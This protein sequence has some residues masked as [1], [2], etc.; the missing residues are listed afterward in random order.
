M[1]LEVSELMEYQGL[2]W[3]LGL[4]GNVFPDLVKVFFTNLKVKE[5]K[6]E[7]RVKEVTMKITP[8]IWMTVVWLKCEGLKIS[9]GNIEALADYN[10]ISFCKNCL[11][12][13]R[14]I[15]RGFSVRGLTMNPRIITFIIVWI[16]T[17]RGHNHAVLHEEDLILMYC[18]VNRLRFNW[19]YVLEEQMEKANGCW[20]I[21]YLMLCLSEDLLSTSMYH[22][23]E[24]L[25]NQWN[26]TMKCMIHI[27]QDWTNQDK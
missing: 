16:M 11:R 25:L 22:L 13:M 4:T 9:K 24:N 2:E 27:A 17:P 8:S 12:D 14:G 18:I 15:M 1:L 5:D 6:S 19:P 3:F 10:K 7:S 26:K 21:R 23:K 20:I